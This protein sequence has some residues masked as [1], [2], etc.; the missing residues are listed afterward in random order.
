MFAQTGDFLGLMVDNQYCI[1]V[2]SF[3]FAGRIPLGANFS[4]QEAEEAHAIARRWFQQRAL[5]LQ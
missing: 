2:D 5:E 3:Y 4:A 1:L